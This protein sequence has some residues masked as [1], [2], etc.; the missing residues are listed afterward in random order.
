[1]PTITDFE[2]DV[3][4]SHSAKDREVVRPIAKRLSDDGHWYANF[5]YYA[6]DVQRKAYRAL[7]RL[8]KLNVRTGKLT[9]LV[10]DRGGTVRDP[11]VHYDGRKIVFSYRKGGTDSFHLY[12]INVDG[13]GLRQLTGG[14]YNDIEPTH[15]GARSG[16]SA[17][18]A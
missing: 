15:V 2:F 10:D 11:Q 12:E 4:L 18:R 6:G 5:G 17:C 9:N 7:G 14:P 13:T 3:F 8:C 1:M 16:D